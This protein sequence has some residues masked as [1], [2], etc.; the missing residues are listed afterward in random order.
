MFWTKTLAVLDYIKA[1]R[2]T[3]EEQLAE[4]ADRES[5]KAIRRAFREDVNR[6]TDRLQAR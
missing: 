4:H 5:R 2:A 6:F 1:R 3:M